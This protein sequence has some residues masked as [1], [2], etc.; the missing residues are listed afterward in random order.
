M[1]NLCDCCCNIEKDI[2][3]IGKE[4]YC[5]NCIEQYQLDTCKTKKC[6]NIISYNGYDGAK[7]NDKNTCS[8]CNRLFC[9]ECIIKSQNLIVCVN[10]LNQ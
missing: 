3:K 7:D 6:T 2:R 9:D 4:Q 8:I 1:N 10:C 5:N